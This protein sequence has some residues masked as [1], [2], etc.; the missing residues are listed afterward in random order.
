M[1]K[2]LFT[3]FY[4]L[5]FAV[6]IGAFFWFREGESGLEKGIAKQTVPTTS[7]TPTVQVKSPPVSYV[8]R[9]GRFVSQSFNNCGPATLSMALS[10]YGKD[11]D[12]ETLAD[13]MRPFHNPRGGIDD[14]SIFAPEFVRYAKEYGYE[15]LE[16]PNGNV[17]MVKKLIANNIPVIVRTWLHPNEDIGHFRIVR[18]YND[19]TQTFLQDDSYEGPNLSYNYDEFLSMWQPFNYGYILVF[20]KE[21]H[22]VVAAI[23]G[24]EMD[25]NVAYRNSITR[26][27]K[28]LTENPETFYPSFN[29]A[30]A[31]YH[32]GEY[33]KTVEQYEHVAVK[34]PP[35]ML[36][37]QLEP[38]QAYQTT[39]DT[40]K[41]FT[42]TDRILSN[43]N[44]AY[45]ELYQ[46]RGEE[47]L[48]QENKEAA[49]VEFEKAVYYNSHFEPAIK[50]LASMK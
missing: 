5:I 49:K 6:I 15:S 37:Y 29:I 34:L 18:G 43:G 45:S 22:D 48:K 7:L 30:T 1:R 25:P 31:S 9:Q 4:F 17:E 11:I 10:F 47:Y 26:A 24:E 28:E 42:L 33:G 8:L 39:G 46:M 12:Q 44:M 27:E 50:A 38:I 2:L 16:R 13:R 40:E 36:W 19:E 23:L 20:P 41:V 3:T 21:K 35:R 14:K 32:L